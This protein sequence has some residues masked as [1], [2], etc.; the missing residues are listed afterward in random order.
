[1]WAYHDIGSKSYK[2]P[3][4]IWGTMDDYGKRARMA[5]LHRS[6]INDLAAERAGLG[7]VEVRALA[8]GLRQARERVDTLRQRLK[9]KSA[10]LTSKT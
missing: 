1:M 5:D 7:P 2:T 10:S 8:G 9:D 4:T 6:F 3:A